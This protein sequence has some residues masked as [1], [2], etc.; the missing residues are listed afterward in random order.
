[1]VWKK[2]LCARCFNGVSAVR[3]SVISLEK[4]VFPNIFNSEEK[5]VSKVFEWLK[6]TILTV[7]NEVFQ[8]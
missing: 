7:N 2:N 4:R 6:K 3:K 1:M 5:G 8:R